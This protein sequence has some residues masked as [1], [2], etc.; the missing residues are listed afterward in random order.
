MSEVM[1]EGNVNMYSDEFL[2]Y[3]VGKYYCGQ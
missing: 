3:R 2:R 1:S